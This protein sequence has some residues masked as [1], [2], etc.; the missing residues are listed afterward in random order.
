MRAWSV[1]L[2]LLAACGPSEEE[3]G[4]LV[5]DAF[6]AENPPGAFGAEIGGKGVW[7]SAGFLDPDCL[8]S[9]DLAHADEPSTRPSSDRTTPRMSPRYETQ[10]WITYS[11]PRGWCLSLGK[12]AEIKVDGVRKVG[13]YYEVDTTISVADPTPYWGCMTDGSVKRVVEVRKGDDGQF[14]VASPVGLYRGACPVPLPG[15]ADRLG[16]VRPAAPPAAPPTQAE[17]RALAERFDTA[18]FER[19]YQEALGMVSCVNLFEKKPFGACSVGELV[20]LGPQFHT[21][22]GPEHGA[23][24]LEYGVQSPAE[25][26]KITADKA[27]PT[28]FHVS[29]THRRTHRPRTFALQWVDGGWRLY[30]VV[31]LKGE[32]LTSMRFLYDLD[33]RDRRDVFERRLAGEQ[34]D[35]KGNAL[36]PYDEPAK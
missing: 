24:W 34:I 10:N 8:T 30:G 19:K 13:G 27:D 6:H 4:Q 7:Y 31:S 29:V 15:G 14:A 9:R 5:V 17:V 28:V 11:T 20:G 22:I 26:G 16:G 18:L 3:I 33:Q 25:F 36:D 1:L 35:E 2:P 21:E 32:G 12:D 23:P